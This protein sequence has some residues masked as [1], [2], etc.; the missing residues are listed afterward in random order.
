MFVFRFGFFQNTHHITG[1][2]S[3][4]LKNLRTVTMITIWV[5][6]IRPRWGRWGN[7]SNVSNANK[8]IEIDRKK[9]VFYKTVNVGIYF[10]SIFILPLIEL[11]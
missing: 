1:I 11:A 10:I 8:Y 3:E 2:K 7:F 5:G 9:M 6:T 4:N